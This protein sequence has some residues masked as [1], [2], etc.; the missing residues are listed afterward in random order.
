M[1]S[2]G[3]VDRTLDAQSQGSR[4][5]IPLGSTSYFLANY[6]RSN[7]ITNVKEMITLGT[8]KTQGTNVRHREQM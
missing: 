5:Q 2:D 7:Q 3:S 4:V 8:C 1:L 6:V